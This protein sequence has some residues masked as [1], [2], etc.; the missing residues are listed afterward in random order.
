MKM[1]KRGILGMFHE[2]HK[3]RIYEQSVNF[4]LNQCHMGTSFALELRG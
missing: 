4:R 3:L 2:C 1:K